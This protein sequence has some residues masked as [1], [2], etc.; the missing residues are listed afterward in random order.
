MAEMRHTVCVRGLPDYMEHDRLEDKLM[1]HFLRERNGGGEISSISIKASDPC[2]IITFEDSKVAL[3]VYSRRHV[4]EVDGKMYELS[5]SFPWQE[6]V[7]LNRVICDMSV[8]IDCT[9]LPLGEENLKTITEKFPGLGIQ[10]IKSQRHCT[11]KGPYSEVNDAVSHLKELLVDFEP[12]SEKSLFF[13]QESNQV[14]SHQKGNDN[15]PDNL[16]RLHFG[17]HASLHLESRYPSPTVN[18]VKLSQAQTCSAEK[19]ED[20]VDAAEVQALSLI[21]EA[22]V[23]AYLCSKSEEYKNILQ[24]HGVHVI[25][26]TAA[27]V[28]TLYLQS[29]AKF[30]TGSK[31]E[32]QMNHACEELSQLYQQVESN[33]RRAHI[34]RSALKLHGEQTAIF[35]NLES[36]LPKV[37]LSFDQTHIYIVGESSEVSQAKQILLLG[38]P[39]EDLKVKQEVSLS[40]SPAYSYSPTS[41]SE[42]MQIDR[43]SSES[44]TMTPK[45]RISDAERRVRTGEEYKLAARF[46]NS[47]MGL[48]GFGLLE[49]GRSREHQ[50]LTKGINTLALASNS[51]LGTAVRVNSDHTNASQVSAFKVTGVNNV[52]EDTLFQKMEPFSF[53]STLKNS[54]QVSNKVSRTNSLSTSR[55]K[56]VFNASLSTP[57][58]AYAG[59]EKLGKSTVES[60]STSTC[61]LRRTNSFSGRPLQKQDTQKTGINEKSHHATNSFIRP[62]SSSLKSRVSAETLPRRAVTV[63]SLMWSYIKEAYDSELQPLISDIQVSESPLDKYKTIVI[64]QGSESTKVEVCQ[65]EVQKLVDVIGLDFCVQNLPL[66][67]LGVTEGN[68]MFKE[69]CS[70]ICSNSSKI[71]LQHAKDAII[72]M[73][74][75]SPCFHA[76]ETLKE[77][78]PREVSNS[79][80]LVNTFTLQGSV[81]QS[82]SNAL[83]N[84]MSIKSSSQIR[85]DQIRAHSENPAIGKHLGYKSESRN[86]AYMLSPKPVAKETLKKASDLEI[87][88]TGPLPVKSSE[89]SGE[90]LG[91]GDDWQKPSSLTT[92]KSQ[93]ATTLT[94]KQINLPISKQLESCVCGANG[95]PTSC[96]VYLCSKC[97]EFHAQCMV[98]SK[99]NAARKPSMAIQ[100]QSLKE[101][102]N[103]EELNGKET[104]TRQKQKQGIQGTMRCTELPMNLPGYEQ[105]RT[106][107]ITYSIP[108]GIQGEEHPN[109]GLPFKGGEFEAYLPLTSKGQVLLQCLERA[110]KQG[111]TFTVSP[112]NNTGRAKIT[113]SRIPHKTKISGGKSGNGYPDSGYLKDLAEAL[114]TCGIEGV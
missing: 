107:K 103:P 7:H 52:D 37:M 106:A 71:V 68:D 9:Y 12:P 65:C 66:E 19:I 82:Q 10:Y 89:E 3:S 13:A 4:L 6:S 36:L 41:E 58:D 47:D 17:G 87:S 49:R 2:A 98:C 113:W 67:D 70:N 22:D 11:I 55:V 40:S 45:M 27:G 76:I 21:M 88:K 62:R 73:G 85:P 64:L 59:L 101:E 20:W 91:L 23:F 39:D 5:L 90:L 1:V 86:V 77:L 34:P 25:D 56:P 112:N 44:S 24:N 74:P 108:D 61:S 81:D 63:P 29:N 42:P 100:A 18:S 96:G 28:T 14:R 97:I 35:K 51:S 60:T 79:G 69:C 110:F 50:D 8:T 57:A 114:R 105:Y 48:L 92:Q 83:A 72:L 93:K 75:K 31:A 53:T 32:T 16:H 104:G 109:P 46:K 94:L 43:A 15:S 33:L 99:I 26:V 30:K 111:F 84:Q 102:Q 54:G 95:S 38:S 80:S 78:F